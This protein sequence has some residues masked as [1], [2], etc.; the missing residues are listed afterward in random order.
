MAKRSDV[1]ILGITPLASKQEAPASER[2]Y[3]EIPILMNARSGYHELGKFL[4]DLENAGRFMKVV[5][6]KIKENLSTPKKHD[7]ELLILTYVLL[8][9]KGI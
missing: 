7:V 8:E 2:A 5:D 1:K 4:S 9:S 6:I 3:Q